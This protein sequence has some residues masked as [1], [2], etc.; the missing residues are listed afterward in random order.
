MRVEVTRGE[1][2]LGES[3][4]VPHRRGRGVVVLGEMLG[5][6][7]GADDL[8]ACC[9]RPVDHLGDQGRLVTVRHGVDNAGLLGLPRQKRPAENIGLDVDHDDVLLVLAAQQGVT[10]TR[11]RIAG[12]LEDDLDI[13]RGDEGGR[14]GGDDGLVGLDALGNG[15]GARLIVQFFGVVRALQRSEGSVLGQIGNT[16][17]AK[18]SRAVRLG[19]EHGAELASADDADLDGL[20]GRLELG[21]LGGEARH[22]EDSGWV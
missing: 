2:L 4:V 15:H 19:D 18:A 22:G 13:R 1:L 14:V 9:P 7:A 11:R 5:A 20:A 17:Q 8:K 12:D 21:K 3:V 6:L 16:G 10:D